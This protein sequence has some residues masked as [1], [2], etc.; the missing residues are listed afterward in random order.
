VSVGRALSRGA[1]HPDRLARTDGRARQRARPQ[2]V[3]PCRAIHLRGP[4]RQWHT[5]HSLLPPK[6]LSQN[7][8]EGSGSDGFHRHY[9][10]SCRWQHPQEVG[11]GEEASQGHDADERKA[12][13]ESTH[14][15]EKTQKITCSLPGSTTSGGKRMTASSPCKQGRTV[16]SW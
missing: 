5:S 13:S 12:E 11:Q 14:A 8:I 1:T 4:C 6:T 9:R 2:R 3:L 10:C 15:G 7:L 16:M